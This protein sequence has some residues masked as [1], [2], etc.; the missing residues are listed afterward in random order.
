M[1]IYIYTYTYFYMHLHL[2]VYI[3]VYI[4][5][6]AGESALNIQL[7]TASDQGPVAGSSK[8]DWTGAW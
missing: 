2:Y 5:I 3:C 1:Y 6:C 8:T 4:Y 7:A